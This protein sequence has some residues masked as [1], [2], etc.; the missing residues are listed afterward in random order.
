MLLTN[1]KQAHLLS[2]KTFQVS[3]SGSE[4]ELL[5]NFQEE[6]GTICRSCKQKHLT[7]LT[8][9]LMVGLQNETPTPMNI[10]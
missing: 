7:S 9:V 6:T 1:Y 8:T 3:K 4:S 10:T 2:S 5:H